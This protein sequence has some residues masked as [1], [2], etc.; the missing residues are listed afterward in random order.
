MPGRKPPEFKM[1]A[2]DAKDLRKI[3]VPLPKEAILELAGGP[4]SLYLDPIR[5]RDLARLVCESLMLLF[6][7][8]RCT[9][10][11]PRLSL[12]LTPLS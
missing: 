3:P 5:R 7:L 12:C 4:F 2:Y 1:V 9:R 10:P 6:P 8:N 11:F